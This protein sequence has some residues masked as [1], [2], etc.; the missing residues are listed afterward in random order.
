MKITDQRG[1][2]TRF[3]DLDVGDYFYD[4]DEE[5][6]PALWCKIPVGRQADEGPFNSIHVEVATLHCFTAESRVQAVEIEIF[7]VRNT[8]ERPA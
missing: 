6:T 8:P 2:L 4:A 7:V 5:D 1:T 3:D